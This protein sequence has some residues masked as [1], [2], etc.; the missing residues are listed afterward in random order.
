MMSDLISRREAIDAFDGVKVDEECCTE[1]DFGY[2]DGIDFVVS[3]LSVM[4]PA[5]P[6][7]KKGMWI[8]EHIASDS[9]ITGYYLSPECSCSECGVIITC[10][11]AYCP[12]CGADMR[13]EK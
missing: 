11:A 9:S 5:Q 3:K 13:G 8:H 10:E 2:N 1:Y 12:N 7:R 4:P 6:E